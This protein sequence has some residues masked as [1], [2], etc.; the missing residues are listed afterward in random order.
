[1]PTI[2]SSS[3]IEIIELAVAKKGFSMDGI[4]SFPGPP[5]LTSLTGINQVAPGC[6]PSSSPPPPTVASSLEGLLLLQL[7]RI[8]QMTR[9]EVNFKVFMIINLW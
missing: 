9:K 1:M 3:D 7:T 5:S 6:E 4:P 8:K 2:R